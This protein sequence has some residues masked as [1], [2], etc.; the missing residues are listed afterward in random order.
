MGKSNV[1]ESIRDTGQDRP[2]LA[3]PISLLLVL[4]ISTGKLR[5]VPESSGSSD[6]VESL[7]IDVHFVAML[8]LCFG[9]RSHAIYSRLE[10]LESRI[11]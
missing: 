2:G 5:T 11:R 4:R 7:C 6:T 10:S 9:E 3:D 1:A 8:G